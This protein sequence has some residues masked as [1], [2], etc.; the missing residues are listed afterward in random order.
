[1]GL[2]PY[3]L[4]VDE[5]AGDAMFTTTHLIRAGGE[6]YVKYHYHRTQKE[7]CYTDTLGGNKHL[8]ESYDLGT[9]CEIGR[10]VELSEDEWN[11]MEGYLP[12][13]PKV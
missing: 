3:L 5:Y 8:L 11:A 6:Q 13:W 7:G 1:M 2:T 12:K 10:I 4:K 9:M